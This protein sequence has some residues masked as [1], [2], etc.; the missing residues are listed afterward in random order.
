MK[1]CSLY[2][3]VVR[4]LQYGHQ[5][6]RAEFLYYR[7]VCIIEVEFKCWTPSDQVNCPLLKRSLHHKGVGKEVQLYIGRLT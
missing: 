5:K 3:N 4:S 7:G 2:C 1:K 6:D